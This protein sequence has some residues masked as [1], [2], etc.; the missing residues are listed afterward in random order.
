MLRIRVPGIAPLHYLLIVFHLQIWDDAVMD[1]SSDYNIRKSARVADG[2]ERRPCAMK[3][4]T[5]SRQS[6]ALVL[7]IDCVIHIIKRKETAF[8]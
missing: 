2:I 5:S 3:Y 4:K 6:Y 7:V 8:V 1:E